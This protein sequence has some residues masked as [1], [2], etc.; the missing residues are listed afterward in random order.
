MAYLLQTMGEYIHVKDGAQ[1]HLKC[2]APRRA[3]PALR[4]GKPEDHVDTQ[5]AKLMARD[6]VRYARFTLTKGAFNN[7]M[8]INNKNQYLTDNVSPRWLA[9]RAETLFTALAYPNDNAKDFVTQMAARSL[10]TLTVGGGVCSLMAYVTAGFLT[11]SAKDDTKIAVVFDGNFDHE[12]VVVCYGESPW[13]VADP[14]VGTTYS[15]LWEHCYFP[16]DA[17][18]VTT[19]IEICRKVS[20]PFGVEFSDAEIRTATRQAKLDPVPE[21]EKLAADKQALADRKKYSW[22]HMDHAYAHPSNVADL[23]QG[24]YQRLGPVATPDMWGQKAL[25]LG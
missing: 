5:Y 10:A 25:S 18:T 8:R 2:R 20:V 23:Q 14:W 17:V 16:Q 21:K 7:Q 3:Q 13:V 11:T 6:A 15:C 9:A 22:F 1:A 24:K 12:Y 4:I 19:D